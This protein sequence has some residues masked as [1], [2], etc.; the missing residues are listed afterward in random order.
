MILTSRYVLDC[1][2]NTTVKQ[3]SILEKHYNRVD[4]KIK[5][6][7]INA[8]LTRK[9]FKSNILIEWHTKKLCNC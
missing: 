9:L 3:S 7:R 2:V 5:F 6:Y 8:I 4:Y 1:L